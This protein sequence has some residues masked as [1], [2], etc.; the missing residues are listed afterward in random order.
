MNTTRNQEIERAVEL[1]EM[2]ADDLLACFGN[3]FPCDKIIRNLESYGILSKTNSDLYKIDLKKLE[4]FIETRKTD[5]EI[6]KE[7]KRVIQIKLEKREKSKNI[8]EWITLII[9]VWAFIR[10]LK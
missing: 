2:F 6:Y 1:K 8:R 9:A 10:T 3:E 5:E 4:N 7:E